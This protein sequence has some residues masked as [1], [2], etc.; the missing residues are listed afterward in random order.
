MRAAYRPPAARAFR[1]LVHADGLVCAAL[2]VLEARRAQAPTS[3][4]RI[5]PTLLRVPVAHDPAAVASGRE[6]GR[7]GSVPV[8][9]AHSLVRRAVL[10]A[11]RRTEVHVLFA[12]R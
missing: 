4:R 9:G 5:R 6:A 10:Q 11:A 3:L 2:T 12:R 1:D 7:T 8:L